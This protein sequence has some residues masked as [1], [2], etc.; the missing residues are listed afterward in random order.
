MH[1]TL[2]DPFSDAESIPETGIL[3]V[4]LLEGLNESLPGGGVAPHK[5]MDWEPGLDSPLLTGSPLGVIS[6]DCLSFLISRNVVIVLTSQKG[7]KDG[8]R[9]G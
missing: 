4:G 6:P 9:R 7:R 2:R 1:A 5:S 3:L 8:M